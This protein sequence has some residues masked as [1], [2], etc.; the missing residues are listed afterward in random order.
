M[1]ETY[2]MFFTLVSL[3]FINYFLIKKNFLLDTKNSFHKS[4]LSKDKI[5]LSGGII[6][7]LSISI[8]YVT[9]F[10]MFKLI[11]LAIFLIGVFSD[12]NLISSPAKRI[13]AQISV[14]LFF[15]H[16]NQIYIYSVRWEFL[17][18][19]L[20]NTYLGY[21]F[22]LFCLIILINGTNFMDGVNT[23]VIG[24]YFFL[25]LSYFFFVHN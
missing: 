4:F 17:D 5:P 10:Y 9:E 23:L 14:V 8:F 15:L 20:Q 16:I 19:Y 2:V 21:I 1:F 22:S 24:Y 6:I 3:I 11:L 7:L 13:V 25:F 18:Y 12:L